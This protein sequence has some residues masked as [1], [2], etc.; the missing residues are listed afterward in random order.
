MSEKFFDTETK[1]YLVESQNE[2]YDLMKILEDQGCTWMSGE[3]PTELRYDIIN[4]NKFVVYNRNNILT[5]STYSFFALQYED[6][7]L[8][9][10]KVDKVK[11]KIER[12][13]WVIN[14]FFRDG[15]R[16]SAKC[17][18]EQKE[19][20]LYLYETLERNEIIRI[21]N[22]DNTENLCFFKDEVNM[23]STLKIGGEND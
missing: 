16:L 23:I 9:D 2:Y 19:H 18:F 4:S 13:L 6:S 12:D 15:S 14:V 20:A 3:K 22:F 17:T 11:G 5:Q 10:W 21:N 8:T 1:Y 7:D